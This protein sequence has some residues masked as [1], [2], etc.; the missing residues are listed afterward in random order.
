ML[1]L[2]PE[3]PEPAFLRKL[4]SEYGNG[5][6]GRQERPIAR[7]RK[8]TKVGEEDDEP[9]YVMEG[10]Q[11]AL[12]RE[13]YEAL[14]SGAQAETQ[15][16]GLSVEN[17][18]IAANKYTDI[19]H[20]HSGQ[21]TEKQATLAAIGGTNKRKVGKIVGVEDETLIC[22]GH[23]PTHVTKKPRAKKIRKQKLSFAQDE[24]QS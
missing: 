5:D 9:T 4:R 1:T 10:S 11:D 7:P 21:S 12:S 16:A 17:V 14:S 18:K 19:T 3:S 23:E 22:D 15:D 20:I 13:E 24:E 6:S 2:K 8:P